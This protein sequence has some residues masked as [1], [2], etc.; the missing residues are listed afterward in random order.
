VANT[1][2]ATNFRGLWTQVGL[3]DELERISMK[4]AAQGIWSDGW[5]AVRHT[6]FYDEKDTASENYVRLSRLEELL[7]P[8]TLVDGT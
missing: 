6:R 4:F 5:L 7:R 3:R 8:Q 2:I 1:L